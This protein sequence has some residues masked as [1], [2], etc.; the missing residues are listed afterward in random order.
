MSSGTGEC[1]EEHFGPRNDS[2]LVPWFLSH[3][4]TFLYNR[5]AWVFP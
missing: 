3:D 5:K 2:N 4:T 1:Y